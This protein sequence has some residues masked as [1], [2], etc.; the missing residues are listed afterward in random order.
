M[1]SG[2]RVFLISCWR[3]PLKVCCFHFATASVASSLLL[4]SC[5]HLAASKSLFPLRIYEKFL[6]YSLHMCRH[7]SSRWTIFLRHVHRH[8][9]CVAPFGPGENA[10]S[11]HR[12]FTGQHEECSVKRHRRAARGRVRVDQLCG[13]AK[14]STQDGAHN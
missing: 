13:T 8:A 4:R 3:R 9:L 5:R 1:F 14:V 12:P 11:A 2:R 10:R 7:V 6:S